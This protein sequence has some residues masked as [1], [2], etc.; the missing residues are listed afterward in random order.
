MRPGSSRSSVNYKILR[1]AVPIYGGLRIY[2]FNLRRFRVRLG[3][4]YMFLASGPPSSC[5]WMGGVSARRVGGRRFLCRGGR[6]PRRS[7][8]KCPVYQGVARGCINYRPIP[9]A[10]D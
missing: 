7:R 6:A 1:T 2:L 3:P 9:R 8:I 5:R 4:T 10:M